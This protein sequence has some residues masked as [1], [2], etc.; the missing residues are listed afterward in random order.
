M[1]TWPSDS[2]DSIGLESISEPDEIDLDDEV[3]NVDD[4]DAA[5]VDDNEGEDEEGEV[6]E[7]DSEGAGGEEEVDSEKFFDT[8]SGSASTS[9]ASAAGSP[10]RRHKRLKSEDVDTEED[11]VGPVTPGPNSRF[12][13]VVPSSRKGGR[14]EDKDVDEYRGFE[15]D[16]DDDGSGDDIEDDWIDPSLPSPSSTSRSGPR[17]L[18]KPLQQPQ[19]LPPPVPMKDHGSPSVSS[20]SSL[21][22]PPVLASKSK[23]SSSKQSSSTSNHSVKLKKEKS[24]K[25]IPVP[26]PHVIYLAQQHQQSQEQHYPF[27]VAP[28][29]DPLVSSP[30]HRVASSQGRSGGGGGVQGKQHSSAEIATTEKRMHTARARDGGRTQSGGVKGILPEG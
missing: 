19:Q 2:D 26:V 7:F 5:V 10:Q 1:P 13:I 9:N 28:V 27:P 11:P 3:D 29:D 30:Q 16:E 4:D 21:S 25:Q 22:T 24:K 12:D 18:P 17:P 23:S 14:E 8:L 6:V 20:S 15:D